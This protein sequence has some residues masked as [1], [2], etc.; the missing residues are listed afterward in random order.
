MKKK[1]MFFILVAVV[2]TTFTSCNRYVVDRSM[3]G[4]CGVWYPKKFCGGKP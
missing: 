3:G 4:A 1:M 2:A